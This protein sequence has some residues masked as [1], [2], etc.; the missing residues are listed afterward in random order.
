MKALLLIPAC[1][2]ER[3]IRTIVE[4]AKGF[5]RDILVVDDGSSDRTEFEAVAAG[6]AVHR[7]RKNSG[8]GEALRAGFAY[9]LAH[10][11]DY[12]LT[13]DGDG[14]H[15]A[16]DIP[17]FFPLLERY[18]LV[19]GSRLEARASAPLIRRLANFTSSLLV[20]ALC[21]FRIPDSQTGFRAYSAE[22]IRKVHLK[23]SHYDLETEVIIKA[24]RQGFRIGHCQIKT[25]YGSEISRFKNLRDSFRFLRVIARALW[26]R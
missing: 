12:I 22:L 2:E 14:Q 21:G 13:M 25:I 15:D 8:K 10:R 6:A 7:L 9:A 26:R 24:A 19:L 16:E 5:I 18:D 20:S 23:C 11:Y 1:N 3:T 17:K 4:T